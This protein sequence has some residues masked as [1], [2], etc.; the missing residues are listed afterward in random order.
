MDHAVSVLYKLKQ[1][2]G[3]FPKG[4]HWVSA[5]I[6]F[7]FECLQIFYLSSTQKIKIPTF[8]V[9]KLDAFKF[10]KIVCYSSITIIKKHFN[11]IKF[12]AENAFLIWM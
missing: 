9:S 7:Y 12:S 1:S 10:T 6:G 2:F 8:H 3:N 11:T 4:Q 5:P